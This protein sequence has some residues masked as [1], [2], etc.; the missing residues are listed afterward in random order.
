MCTDENNPEQT[1]LFFPGDSNTE[2]TKKNITQ[3]II[4]SSQLDKKM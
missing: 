3:L 4:Y 2:Y 1:G